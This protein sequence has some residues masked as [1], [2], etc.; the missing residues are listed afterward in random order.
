MITLTTTTAYYQ[1]TKPFPYAIMDNCL[2]TER[3]TALQREILS[4]S[5]DQ[6]DR[7]DNPFEQKYTLRDKFHFPPLLKALFEELESDAFVHQLSTLCGYRLLLDTTRNF[8]GVHT[9]GP[10]DKLDI[11][12]DAGL[13]PTMNLSYNQ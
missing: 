8:W 2:D 13:H 5:S 1:N 11:H 7:Y 10:G 4:I 6:W 9:Y 3:A 12:V